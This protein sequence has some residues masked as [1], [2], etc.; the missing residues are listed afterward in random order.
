MKRIIIVALGCLLTLNISFAG[1]PSSSDQ[2]WLTAVEK[3]I[4]TGRTEVSTP[5]KD[6]IDLLQDWAKKKGLSVEVTKNDKG[7]HAEL[8]VKRTA[9]N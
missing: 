5:S 1:N 9:K 6:R 4:T 8:S 7:Y 3:M 2:K